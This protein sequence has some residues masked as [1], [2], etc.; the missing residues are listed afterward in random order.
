MR[1]TQS[2]QKSKNP[3]KTVN[4][5]KKALNV[6]RLDVNKTHCATELNGLQDNL[7]DMLTEAQN[8]DLF[9]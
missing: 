4:M 2:K 6:S 7:R 9:N 5:F 1:E 3:E 8:T